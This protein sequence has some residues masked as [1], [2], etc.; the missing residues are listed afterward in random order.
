MAALLL[1]SAAG[2]SAQ[3]LS[4]G[5]RVD[6][7][8]NR[9]PQAAAADASRDDS[10]VEPDD[11]NTWEAVIT[12]AHGDVSLLAA[13]SK[14]AVKAETGMPLA[15]GD[16]VVAKD[17][18]SVEISFDGGAGLL[19][20]GG[21]SSISIDSLQYDGTAL[22]L[23]SGILLGM[24]VNLTDSYRSFAIS[25]AGGV[26]TVYGTEFAVAYMPQSRESRVGVF[27]DGHAGVTLF[28]ASQEQQEL[29]L[30]R[31]QEATFRDTAK[32]VRARRMVM[33]ADYTAAAALLPGRSQELGGSWKR[34][35]LKQRQALRERFAP[36]A[37]NSGDGGQDGE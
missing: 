9:V 31:E 7:L 29:M 26:C 1:L 10:A 23:K 2:A 34:M 12:D 24:M 32:T 17:S 33:L 14:S 8:A 20:L 11:D 4:S 37:T 6:G 28:N 21:G 27:D 18:S 35:P 3:A 15:S 25:T 19:Q 30:G 22:S 13:G 16:V 5:G 36:A